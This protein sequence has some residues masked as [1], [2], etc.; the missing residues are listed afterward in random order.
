MSKILNIHI[1]RRRTAVESKS[2]FK[3]QRL[4]YLSNKNY[5]ITIIIQKISTIHKFDYT[6]EQ[7]LESHY[8]KNMTIFDHANPKVNE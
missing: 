7:I 2:K 6:I 5:C 1:L 8:L 4:G 3:T